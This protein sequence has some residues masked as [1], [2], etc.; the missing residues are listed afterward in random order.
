MEE[1]D[2]G[3]GAGDHSQHPCQ[4]RRERG[5]GRG[6]RGEGIGERGNITNT[7]KREHIG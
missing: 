3:A 2:G 6:D 5:E 7:L 1:K 4:T